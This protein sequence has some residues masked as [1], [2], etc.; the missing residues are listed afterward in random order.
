[1]LGFCFA[2]NNDVVSNRNNTRKILESLVNI[3]LED[4]LG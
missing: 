1:M 3:L 2:E 4:I